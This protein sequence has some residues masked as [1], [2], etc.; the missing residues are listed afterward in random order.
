[1]GEKATSMREK[2]NKLCFVVDRNS[3]K[4]EIKK[5]IESSYN[6]KVLDVNIIISQGKKKAYVRLD[7]KYPAEEIASRFGVL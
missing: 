6:V 3:T 5:A 1:M 7:P 2:E 4:N